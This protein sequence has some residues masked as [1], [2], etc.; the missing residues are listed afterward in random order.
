[1]GVYRRDEHWEDTWC[2]LPSYCLSSKSFLHPVSQD[3]PHQP[4]KLLFLPLSART[5]LRSV[6]KNLVEG[7]EA[8]GK[9][10]ELASGL[11]ALSDWPALLRHFSLACSHWFHF[12]TFL[13]PSQKQP[14][15]VSS[16]KSL[17]RRPQYRG[18][19]YSSKLNGTLLKSLGRSSARPLFQAFE[20]QMPP[21][22]FESPQ[23]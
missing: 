5:L 3:W 15:H 12:S 17:Q 11:P 21:L 4:T 8:G 2:W 23:P 10:G 18:S 1:M 22:L 16:T 20:F 19:R 7:W 9:D 6:W 13:Q 14:Q